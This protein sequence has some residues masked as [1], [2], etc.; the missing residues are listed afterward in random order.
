M[1]HLRVAI[2]LFMTNSNER[3]WSSTSVNFLW[4]S[5]GL[6]IS[7][8]GC[9]AYLETML[10]EL[11]IGLPLVAT[12]CCLGLNQVN[13]YY[14]CLV[15]IL[16]SDS[17]VD[18]LSTYGLSSHLVLGN[19]FFFRYFSRS[20]VDQIWCFHCYCLDLRRPGRCPDCYLFGS[21]VRHQAY[22][23]VICFSTSFELA[24]LFYIVCIR[25]TSQP[26]SWFSSFCVDLKYSSVYDST[27]TIFAFEYSSFA[28][29]HCRMLGCSIR[30]FSGT[31]I[32][33]H[34]CLMFC[35]E[36]G[37]RSCS[38][39]FGT[40]AAAMGLTNSSNCYWSLTPPCFDSGLRALSGFDLKHIE[41]SILSLSMLFVQLWCWCFWR[42]LLCWFQMRFAVVGEGLTGCGRRS[43]GNCSSAYSSTF[44]F[45]A[46]G[47]TVAASW[48]AGTIWPSSSPNFIRTGN[49]AA[50]K[51]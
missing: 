37:Q 40:R 3:S 12:N 35:F 22:S 33:S 27:L 38:L 19:L 36:V 29:C 1:Y 39:I 46:A 7:M 14:T 8:T 2:D 25:P 50:A 24:N 48:P 49:S 51:V 28:R 44:G 20:E 32:P 41:L 43:V 10:T 18:R 15:F 42:F 34:C 21:V 31:S 5:H 4:L 26:I 13:L 16:P 30:N 17:T 23:V 6:T 11:R 45:V 9:S 47:D